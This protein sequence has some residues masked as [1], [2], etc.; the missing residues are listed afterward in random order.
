MNAE[1]DDRDLAGTAIKIGDYIVY[2]ASWGRCPILKY[3]RVVGFGEKEETSYVRAGTEL[4]FV[5]RVELKIK[6][7][8]VD[9][10]LDVRQSNGAWLYKWELQNAKRKNTSVTLSFTDRMLVVPSH[11]VPAQACKVL[12]RAYAVQLSR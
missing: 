1:L 8:T 5:T 12:D 7:V 6:A 10:S 4:E 11:M 9:R 2:A 3:G